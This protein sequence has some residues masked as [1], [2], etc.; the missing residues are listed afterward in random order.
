MKNIVERIVENNTGLKR[1]IKTY[2]LD[3][4]YTHC[5]DYHESLVDNLAE[6]H[7][8][9]SSMSCEDIRQEI[10]MV[11]ERDVQ[12]LANKVSQLEDLL[13][14]LKTNESVDWSVEDANWEFSVMTKTLEQILD[15]PEDCENQP[16]WCAEGIDCSSIDNGRWHN[17]TLQELGDDF[18]VHYDWSIQENGVA[19]DCYG[20]ELEPED[21]GGGYTYLWLHGA[22]WTDELVREVIECE[23]Y[24]DDPVY[25]LEDQGIILCG[26]SVIPVFA[27]G[28]LDID[29]LCKLSECI[30]DYPDCVATVHC[31]CEGGE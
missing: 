28:T 1:S 24:E 11:S 3:E 5:E 31:L 22:G 30:F 18:Y 8:E 19:I 23:L 20:K 27:N 21:D 29:N 26:N 10:Q 4:I 17:E 14:Q 6:D 15:V 13:K 9:I 16:H 2:A 25:L 7:S 12:K